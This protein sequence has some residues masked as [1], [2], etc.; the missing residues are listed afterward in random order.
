[1]VSRRAQKRAKASRSKSV[2]RPSVIGSV[3][4]PD[5]QPTGTAGVHNIDF[6]IPDAAM[7]AI[8]GTWLSELLASGNRVFT[9][10]AL[11]DPNRTTLAFVP[12]PPDKKG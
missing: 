4:G 9:D 8:D 1:M 5:G 7:S 3:P 10:P 6:Y 12:K 2:P 11:I